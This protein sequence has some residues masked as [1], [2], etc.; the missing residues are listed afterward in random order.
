MW[1]YETAPQFRN[2]ETREEAIKFKDK[3]D[4]ESF[5]VTVI[6]LNGIFVGFG[7]TDKPSDD[8]KNG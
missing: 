7:L 3:E 5:R 8:S 1:H 2:F 4:L 6:V